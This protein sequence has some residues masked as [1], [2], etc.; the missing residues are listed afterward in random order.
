M[1]S[2]LILLDIF[3][4][5][6]MNCL[7]SLEYIKKINIK[8]NRYGLETIL[9]HPPEWE[10]EKS[11]K[12]ILNALK[13]RKIKIPIIIDK[14]KKIINKFKINFWPTQILIDNG[15][16]LYKHIGEGNY[17]ALE[18]TI[19]K[20]LKIKTHKIF[21]SEPRYSAYPA[22]Y[23]GKRKNGSVSKLKKKLKFGVVC[24]ENKWVRNQ[25]YIKSLKGNAVLTILTKGITTNFVSKSVDGKPV[26]AIIKLNNKFIKKIKIDK[27][28]LYNLI[29]NK[30]NN[31]QKE[32][33]IITP[34]NLCIYSFSFQ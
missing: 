19:I 10:F 21:N 33:A 34:K 17:K 13:K 22:V 25:E 29:K 31:K 20:N 30:N 15:K 8:Y 3:S 24:I 6:C 14:N 5:S 9:I 2:G 4:Y 27:P 23:C 32:L 16:I 11:T 28:Q 7:R 1:K 18:N 12:N 26:T